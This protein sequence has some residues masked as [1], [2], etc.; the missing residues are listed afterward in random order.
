MNPH[1]QQAKVF[2]PNQPWKPITHVRVADQW[3]AVASR[4]DLVNAAREDC[5]AALA[6]G[7][8]RS[9]LVFDSNGQGI[10]LAQTDAQFRKDLDQADIIHADGQFVV[11]VSETLCAQAIPERAPTTD[12]IHD[13]AKMAEEHGYSFYLLGG[14]EAAS[15]ACE[16]QLRE[17]YPRLK[18]VGRSNGFFR[19]KEQ[20][21]IDDIRKSAPDFLWVGLG[22]PYEQHF[23]AKY[24]D[25]LNAVW[26]ITCGG[27]FN[28]ITG[29]YSRAPEWM[30]NHGLEWLYRMAKEPKRL[31]WRY[32]TTTPHAL[33]VAL[34]KSSKKTRTMAFEGR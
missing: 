27:C 17:M 23:C 22:K 3:V 30:Q 19:G 1:Q 7:R 24:K 4:R 15:V 11:K 33:I 9:R 13:F 16:T 28:F 31:G 10:S 6:N 18:I 26:V 14:D 8:V 20:T 29:H 5:D 25:Q 21:V 12:M 2:M 32:L 34:T